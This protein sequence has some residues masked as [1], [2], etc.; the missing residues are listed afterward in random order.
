MARYPATAWQVDPILAQGA[1]VAIEDA[2]ELA[3]RLHGWKE[4]SVSMQQALKMYEGAT[5]TRAKILAWVSDV[6]QVCGSPPR[7][8]RPSPL[9]ITSVSCQVKKATC[10]HVLGNVLCSSSP[11][12]SPQVLGQ[13]GSA[14]AIAARDAAFMAAPAALKGPVFDAMIKLSLSRGWGGAWS[15]GMGY[16]PLPFP[17]TAR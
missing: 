9:H 5:A 6:S 12:A 15:G 14:G 2:Y 8:T 13:M 16:E 7:S 17:I 3:V 10:P 4:G 11:C 1:G